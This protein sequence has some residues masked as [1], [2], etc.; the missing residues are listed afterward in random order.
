MDE[1]NFILMLILIMEY[2]N[3]T[4]VL[5]DAEHIISY[6]WTQLQKM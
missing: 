5:C 4:T 2:M 6:I 1:L 3:Q